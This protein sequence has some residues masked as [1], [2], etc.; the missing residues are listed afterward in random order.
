MVIV[1]RDA[2]HMHIQLTAQFPLLLEC[3]AAVS[4]VQFET[5]YKI[6][7]SNF[8][9]LAVLSSND[10]YLLSNVK[11]IHIA[12]FCSPIRLYIYIVSRNL[13]IECVCVIL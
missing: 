10:D 7:E 13:L 3:V 8:I 11:H 12:H 1:E 5:I 6:K 2:M 9:L 4:V